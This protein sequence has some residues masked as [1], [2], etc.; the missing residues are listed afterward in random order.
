LKVWDGLIYFRTG[1]RGGRSPL[2][3]LNARESVAGTLCIGDWVN[4]TVGVDPWLLETELQSSESLPANV[5][6]QQQ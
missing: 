4:I 5:R 6:R 3:R 2:R 1:C